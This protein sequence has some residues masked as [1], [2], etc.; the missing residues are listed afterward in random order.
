MPFIKIP[1]DCLIFQDENSITIDIP[2]SV[3]LSLTKDYQKIFK[4]KGILKYKRDS[5]LSHLNNLRQEWD[6]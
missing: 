6:S 1:K 2:E 3:L 4:A 5:L